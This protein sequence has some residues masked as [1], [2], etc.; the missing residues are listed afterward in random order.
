MRSY[1]KQIYSD[2]ITKVRQNWS[3]SPQLRVPSACIFLEDKWYNFPAPLQEWS[4]KKNLEPLSR[5]STGPTREEGNRGWIPGNRDHEWPG[6]EDR[7]WPWGS[8][9]AGQNVTMRWDEDDEGPWQNVHHESRCPWGAQ[10]SE[11]HYYVRFDNCSD[12]FCE[13]QQERLKQVGVYLQ[14]LADIFFKK[15]LLMLNILC[16]AICLC[17]IN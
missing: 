5:A 7:M 17:N 16:K 14:M 3:I 6:S 13:V 11:C 8:R 4:L 1:N 9:P 2:I 12:R 15:H 10:R